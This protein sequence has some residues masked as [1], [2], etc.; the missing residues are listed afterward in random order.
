MKYGKFGF[1]LQKHSFIWV[2]I[3][4]FFFVAKWQ[5]FAAKVFKFL[6]NKK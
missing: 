4:T 5:R 2:A 3:P 6:I 1:F